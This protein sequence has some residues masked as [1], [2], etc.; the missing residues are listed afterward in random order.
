M[1]YR[2]LDSEYDMQGQRAESLHFEGVYAVVAAVRSRLRCFH[3]EWWE[4]LSDGIP[5]E[6]LVGR[7]DAE[8]QQIADALIRVRVLET[9]GVIGISDYKVFTTGRA[10]TIYMTIDTE[11]GETNVEVSV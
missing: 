1:K 9:E 10:R 3:G 2:R 7:L 8:K 6:A 11:F 5:L 4:T